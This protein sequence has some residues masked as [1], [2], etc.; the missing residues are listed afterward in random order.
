[1]AVNIVQ[2]LRISLLNEIDDLTTRL[3]ERPIVDKY[4]AVNQ[5]EMERALQL[6]DIAFRA[7]ERICVEQKTLTGGQSQYAIKDLP[8]EEQ[9]K[10]RSVQHKIR[11]LWSLYGPKDASQN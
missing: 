8:V 2:S 9:N 1:M 5:S 10:Y 11:L 4:T 7:Y 3:I 6:T